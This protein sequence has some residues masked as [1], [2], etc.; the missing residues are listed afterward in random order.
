VGRVEPDTAGTL[1]ELGNQQEKKLHF[2]ISKIPNLNL[3]GRDGIRKLGVSVDALIQ[4]K[5]GVNKVDI[6][7]VKPSL[8]EACLRHTNTEDAVPPEEINY[9]Y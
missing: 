7:S 4:N 1:H 5:D 2:V 9:Y 8:K 3:L 6:H